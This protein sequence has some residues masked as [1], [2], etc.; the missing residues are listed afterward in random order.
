MKI[1][2][3]KKLLLGSFV[4]F[5]FS[6]LGLAESLDGNIVNLE[7]VNGKIISGEVWAK[8]M[9]NLK[10][11]PYGNGD[12]CSDITNLKASLEINPEKATSVITIKWD[13]E[14][15]MIKFNKII[16]AIYWR[17]RSSSFIYSQKEQSD[18]DFGAMSLFYVTLSK[19]ANG[20]KLSTKKL[21]NNQ[22]ASDLSW[23][24]EGK[25]YVYSA[26]S[27]IRIKDFS[28][29]KVWATKK[30]V[31]DNN[32]SIVSDEPIEIGYFYWLE[33]DKNII[34]MWKELY[35]DEPTGYAM[36]DTTQFKL[37]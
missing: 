35:D 16:N 4:L 9:K 20:I 1:T 6:N 25:Y 18:G 22:A 14:T 8:T 2:F 17:P 37:K 31:F 15:K 36:I 13:K 5:L 26:H 12:H 28:T 32:E 30:I 27:S 3:V 24:S 7:Q 19:T 11:K 29:G 21:T 34:F 10:R 33:N 23:S